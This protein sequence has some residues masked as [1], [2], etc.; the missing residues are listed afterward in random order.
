MI[1][2]ALIFAAGRGERMLPYTKNTPKPLLV[3]ANKPLLAHHLNQ[4]AT[5]GIQQVI[6][7]HAY[8]GYQIRQYVGNGQAFGLQVEY[9]PEPPGGLETAG[10]LAFIKKANWVTDEILLCVNADIYTS[11]LPNSNQE[12]A[13]NTD[14]HLVLIPSQAHLPPGNFGYCENNQRVL[15][16]PKKFIFSGICYYR[17][18]ALDDLYLGRYSIRDWLYSKASQSQ[19]TAEIYDGSWFDVGHPDVLKRLNPDPA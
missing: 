8:L 10:T 19:L 2:T 14:G 17:L 11:Y 15:P 1:K 13:D 4:L 7:N 18:K 16:T 5:A 9:L 3:V 6:I 12:L